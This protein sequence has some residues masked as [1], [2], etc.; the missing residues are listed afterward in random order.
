MTMLNRFDSDKVRPL[1]IGKNDT[2]YGPRIGG[3]PPEG[4]LPAK[5]LSNTRYLVTMPIDESGANELSLFTSF[6]Y[7]T[8]DP[9]RDFYLNIGKIFTREDFVQVVIHSTSKRSDSSNLS[10]E[11]PGCSVEILPPADDIVVPVGGELLLPNKMGGIPY[12]YCAAGNYS[13]S[14]EKLLSEGF[15][16]F[17]QL[18]WGGYEPAVPFVWP[19][20]EY[21]FH[22]LAK[23][24]REGVT[25]CYGWG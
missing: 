9:A 15:M 3:H 7:D 19:F 16:L 18:T 25:W 1:L 20:D 12:V 17:L 11:L 22:L 24:S 23:Q 13:L 4:V 5:V 8:G 6:D 21:T 14:L 2:N 10:C